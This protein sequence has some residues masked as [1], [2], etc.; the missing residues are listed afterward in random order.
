MAPLAGDRVRPQQ[1]L[2]VDDDTAAA[3]RTQDDAEHDS[4]ARARTVDGLG[5]GEA[6]GIVRH[7]NVAAEAPL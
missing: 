6:V 4:V 7:A 2:P 1:H 3:A 5:Q